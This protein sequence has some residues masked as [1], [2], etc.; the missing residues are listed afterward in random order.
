MLQPV[1]HKSSLGCKCV[2]VTRAHDVV[3]STPHA[4]AIKTTAEKV[5]VLIQATLSNYE[6]APSGPT[7]LAMDVDRIFIVGQRVANFLL[8]VVELPALQPTITAERFQQVMDIAQGLKTRLW[9]DSE[10]IGRQLGGIGRVG[11][12]KLA[13]H[14]LTTY[15]RLV[16]ASTS[17]LEKASGRN[18]GQGKVLLKEL[19]SWP[20]LKLEVT[21]TK[22]TNDTKISVMVA[23]VKPGVLGA[24]KD[25]FTS[26]MVSAVSGSKLLLAKRVHLWTLRKS[27]KAGVQ[28]TFRVPHAHH[29]IDVRLKCLSCKS[30]SFEL[31]LPKLSLQRIDSA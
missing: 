9:H 19:L 24:S 10:H 1:L 26:W 6:I 12:N 20:L 14:K 15:S 23:A 29:A 17:E 18:T 22:V 28:V 25:K 21:T 8:A 11:A 5:S 2:G 16:Q 7:Q 13:N 31:V 30:W 3:L 4:G 27:P